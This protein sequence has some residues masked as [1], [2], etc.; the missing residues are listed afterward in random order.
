MASLIGQPLVV[1]IPVNNDLVERAYRLLKSQY[2]RRDTQDF[3]VVKDTIK[4]SDMDRHIQ[5]LLE[6]HRNADEEVKNF[7]RRLKFISEGTQ[8]AKAIATNRENRIF[9]WVIV[10]SRRKTN[11]T[12]EHKILIASMEKT[13]NIRSD[14]SFSVNTLLLPVILISVGPLIFPSILYFYA[15]YKIANGGGTQKIL[16]QLNDEENKKCP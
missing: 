15:L 2:I 10:A 11:T 5:F 12:D 9:V 6:Q 4:H 14:S 16:R 1:N 3:A 13:L 7:I 8:V